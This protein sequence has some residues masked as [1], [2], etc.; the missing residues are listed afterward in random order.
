MGQLQ[1]RMSG[2][3]LNRLLLASVRYNRS[4]VGYFFPTQILKVSDVQHVLQTLFGELRHFENKKQFE[5]I[6]KH[7]FLNDY[8]CVRFN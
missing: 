6:C 1:N 3:M 4:I 7:Q 8:R 5:D 2:S